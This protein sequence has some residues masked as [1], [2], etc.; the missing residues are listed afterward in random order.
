MLY[1]FVQEND[2][3]WCWYIDNFLVVSWTNKKKV[4]AQLED[5]KNN[6]DVSLYRAKFGIENKLNKYF[7]QFK[8]SENEDWDQKSTEV[9]G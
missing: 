8:I 6:I 9:K 3:V 4:M 1:T 7:L 5:F 2:W